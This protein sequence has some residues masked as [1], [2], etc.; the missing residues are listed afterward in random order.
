MF[1]AVKYDEF[2][3]GHGASTRTEANGRAQ[4]TPYNM[5][6]MVLNEYL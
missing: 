5:H 6:V 2:R 4:Q 1:L 3:A